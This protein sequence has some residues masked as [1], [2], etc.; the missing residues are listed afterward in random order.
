[1]K[2]A[3]VPEGEIG[4]I[5]HLEIPARP[6]LLV[7]GGLVD[8]PRDGLHARLRMRIVRG[9]GVAADDVGG[10]DGNGAEHGDTRDRQIG[11]RLAE[12]LGAVQRLERGRDRVVLIAPD[13]LEQILARLRARLPRPGRGGG[14]DFL[15]DGRGHRGGEGRKVFHGAVDPY[16][17]R[18]PAGPAYPQVRRQGLFSLGRR[19]QFP[20]DDRYAPQERQVLARQQILELQGRGVAALQHDAVGQGG[21]L[22]FQ[23]QGQLAFHPGGL[24]VGHT[25]AQVENGDRDRLAGPQP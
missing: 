17:D 22:A 11:R 2:E 19:H 24:G 9:V 4:T 13:A 16:R 14:A 18:L 8:R 23:E 20:V 5:Q 21:Q 12:Q 25:G 3:G 7:A 10:T 6:A 15:F 1:M